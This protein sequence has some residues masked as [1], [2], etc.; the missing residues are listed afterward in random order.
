MR[1]EAVIHT[2]AEKDA[3]QK[4]LNE[5]LEKQQAKGQAKRKRMMELEAEK[6][7]LAPALSDLE[8]ED[9]QKKSALRK[10]AEELTNENRD[11]VKKMNQL[12]GV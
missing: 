8:K 10:R 4:I 12:V 6:K 2:Q 1:Q 3:Q 5:Q 9:L 11:E 7:K